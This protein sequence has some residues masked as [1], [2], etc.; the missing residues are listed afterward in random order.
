MYFQSN[1]KKSDYNV[2]S[3][4]KAYGKTLDILSSRSIE[5]FEASIIENMAIS[6]EYLKDIVADLDHIKTVGEI[7]KKYPPEDEKHPGINVRGG[8]YH[9]IEDKDKHVEQMKAIR[10]QALQLSILTDEIIEIFNVINPTGV[11]EL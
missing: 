10:R 7:A 11:E 9:V 1:I 5:S 8:L 6:V 2:E 3:L 4:L